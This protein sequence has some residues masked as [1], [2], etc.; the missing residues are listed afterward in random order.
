MNEIL[1][2]KKK[3]ENGSEIPG[4]RAEVVSIRLDGNELLFG[5]LFRKRSHKMMLSVVANVRRFKKM[6]INFVKQFSH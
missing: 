6:S 5:F 3:L 1:R 2:S 4:Q